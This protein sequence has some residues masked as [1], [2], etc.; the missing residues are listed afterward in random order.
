VN[1]DGQVNIA[2]VTAL[3]DYLLSGDESTVD[4][5]ASDANQDGSINIA[6]VTSLIDYLLSGAWPEPKPIDLWYLTGDRVGSNPWENQGVSSIGRGLIPLYPV[7]EFDENGE[8][9][10][11]YTGFFGANDAVMLIHHPGSKDDCWG[12][13][14]SGIFG[15]GGEEITAIKTGQDGYFNIMLNTKTDSFYFYPYNSTAMM[16]NTIN[17]VGYHSDW[18]VTDPTYNMTKLNPEKENHNW[19]FRNFTLAND[20]EVKFAA[21]ND[22]SNNWGAETFPFGRGVQGGVNIPVKAGTYDVY[23]ND[24]TGDYNFIKK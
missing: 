4:L 5:D 3:I 9:Q 24:I 17:I 21:D 14:P 22:W 8:G 23:F 10:L 2:D 15:H 7:G 18:A 1:A 6:D 11:S 20:S 16:F 19:I 13:K 12:Y